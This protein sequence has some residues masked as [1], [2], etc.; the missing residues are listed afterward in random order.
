MRFLSV[1]L[2]ACVFFFSSFAGLDKTVA[3]HGKRSGCHGMM[4]NSTCPHKKS[5][6][7]NR[8]CEKQ[9]CS[10]MFTC[11]ICGFFRVE[12][13]TIKSPPLL[14]IEKSVALYKIGN[15]TDY[16]PADW[17]PPKSC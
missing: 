4:S 16:Y 13:L 10:L 12:P 7:Q 8:G 1:V 3:S 2:I 17:K 14:N 6:T 11:S 5:N 15:L 9:S